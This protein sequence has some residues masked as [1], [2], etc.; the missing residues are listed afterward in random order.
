MCLNLPQ[1]LLFGLRPCHQILVRVLKKASTNNIN[2]ISADHCAGFTLF[3]FEA[4]FFFVHFDI[5]KDKEYRKDNSLL[6]LVKINSEKRI[7]PRCSVRK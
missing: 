3:S 6:S 1:C 5:I 7:G 4:I 2:H